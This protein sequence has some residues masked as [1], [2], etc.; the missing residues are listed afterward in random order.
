M[1]SKPKLKSSALYFSLIAVLNVVVTLLVWHTKKVR[2]AAEHNPLAP[3]VE[4]EPNSNGFVSVLQVGLW[5]AS[6][7]MGIHT[8][9]SSCGHLLLKSRIT[10]V[11]RLQRAIEASEITEATCDTLQYPIRDALFTIQLWLVRRCGRQ[12]D[13]DFHVIVRICGCQPASDLPYA[14]GHAIANFDLDATCACRYAYANFKSGFLSKRHAGVNFIYRLPGLI[15]V[16]PA[17]RCD[18]RICRRMDV[19]AIQ[20]LRNHPMRVAD[21]GDRLTHKTTRILGPLADPNPIQTFHMHFSHVINIHTRPSAFRLKTSFRLTSVSI[22]VTYLSLELN[23][24]THTNT[25]LQNSESRHKPP[26]LYQ[27][28]APLSWPRICQVTIFCFCTVAFECIEDT[29]RI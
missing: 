28:Y 9:Y 22:P 10:Q 26:Q 19:R 29:T 6:G 13:L 4:S 14:C 18:P 25:A 21:F 20:R 1:A 7:L 23:R 17:I 27:S 8:L 11:A 24:R 12:F 2:L 16:I 15:L 5:I 3:I